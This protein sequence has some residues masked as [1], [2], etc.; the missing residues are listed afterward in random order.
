MSAGPSSN[1]PLKALPWA[2]QQGRAAELAAL[3]YLQSQGLEVV[4]RNARFRVGELDLVMRE[5][6]ILVF[7]EVRSRRPSRFGSAVQTID[8]HKQRRVV[9]AAQCWLSRH[10][11][12]TY[13]S[14]R[15][16]VVALDGGELQWIPAA[17][18]ADGVL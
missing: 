10:Q 16:D 9:R 18:Q 11:S 4:D 5:R 13:S 17:F 3:R 2:Q 7:V 1:S 8:I 6:T 14:I 15:F 12:V